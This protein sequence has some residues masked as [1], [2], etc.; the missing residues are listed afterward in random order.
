MAKVLLGKDHIKNPMLFSTSVENLFISELLPTAPGNFVKVYMLGLMNAEYGLTQDHQTTANV[1]G[2]SLE[3]IENAWAYWEEKGA[4]R[5]VYDAE[6]H[7]YRIQFISQLDEL[8]G[9]SSSAEETETGANQVSVVAPAETPIADPMSM[10]SKTPASSPE[11]ESARLQDLEI[12]ALYEQLQEAKGGTISQME[13]SR[14]RDAINIYE[15]TPD[16]YSYAIKY[17]Q[18]LDNYNVK[19]ITNVAL[20]WKEEGCK[21]IIQVKELLDKE[22]KRNAEFNRIFQ[23]VGYRRQWTPADREM[24]TTWLDDW[25]FSM[26]EILDAC[27]KTAG[28]R[29]PDLRYVN[30]ILEN[31]MREAGGINTRKENGAKR[32]TG[33][34]NTSGGDSYRHNVSRKVLGDYYEYL[35]NKAEL[36]Y[37][38]HRS[39]ARKEIPGM[40]NLLTLEDE[41]RKAIAMSFSFSPKTK[42]EKKIQRQKSNDLNAQKQKL[43]EENG[44][45]QDYLDKKYKCEKCRDSGIT[46][47]GEFCTCTKDRVEEAYRWNLKRGK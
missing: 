22:S 37:Q 19:Y 46:D 21:D 8:Y 4:V 36:E 28:M 15:I 3:D 9:G 39:T 45:P 47:T 26:S 43:L 29:E 33:S 42:E 41:L 27:S 14:I 23:A 16:V 10:V 6:A 35:R 30:R 11:D 40:A 34:N 20:R 5:Q 13:A 44:Y 38:D 18:E 25:H 32:S 24:M 12:A 31:K 1:L 17:C 7:A 2:M